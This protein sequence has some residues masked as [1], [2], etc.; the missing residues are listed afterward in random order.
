[1]PMTNM[2]PNLTS[3]LTANLISEL[4]P[5][6]NNSVDLGGEITATIVLPSILYSTAINAGAIVLGGVIG[7]VIALIGVWITQK[8]SDE[9]EERNRAEDA[10]KLSREERKKAYVKFATYMTKLD[11]I[12]RIDTQDLATKNLE[13]IVNQFARY[14][15][16]I[17]LV[18]PTIANEMVPVFKS[19]KT[20]AETDPIKAVHDAFTQFNTII[21]PLM[22]ADIFPPHSQEEAKAKIWWRFWK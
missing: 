7:G 3:Q 11:L 17:M 15:S 21:I 6:M 13:T 4:I 2:D 16:E 19:M 9:R 14:W 10:R 22:L 18:N 12:A 20:Y 8:H 5:M 1:M